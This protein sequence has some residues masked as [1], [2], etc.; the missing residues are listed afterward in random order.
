M[1]TYF[2]QK[3]WLVVLACFFSFPLAFAHTPETGFGTE[4]S[5]E[6]VQNR[7][8]WPAAVK[9]KAELP[10]GQLYLKQTELVFNFQNRSQLAALDPHQVAKNPTAARPTEL[11]AHAYAMQFLGAAKHTILSGARKTPGYRN[12]L[13]GNDPS[14]WASDVAAYEEVAYPELYPGT[15]L[16]LYELNK[17]LK[18][19]FELEPGAN[20]DKIRIQYNGAD[21]V[22]IQDGKLVVNTS[23]NTVT[24]QRPYA[25]QIKNGRPIEV[26]CEFRISNNVVSFV[27]PKGFN[28]K[29][30]LTI[31]PTL[32]FSTY[33]GS[34]ADNWGFTAT[35]DQ[36]GN[37][38]S[39]GV[40]FGSGYPV[41]LGAYQTNFRGFIDI[42]IIKYN[43]ALA[44]T[45]SRVYATYLG[46]SEAD[47][48]H[49]LVVNSQNELLVLGTTSSLNYPVSLTG[50]KR[51]FNGGSSIDPFVNFGTS[52]FEYINGSD[53]VITKLS[54]S[55][56]G[57]AGSTFLGGTATAGLLRL[58]APLTRNSGDLFGGYILPDANDNVYVASSTNS[59]NYPVQNAFQ[60][61]YGGNGSD[62]VVS[63]FN[64]N[65]SS[66]L[67]STYA[68][69]S[70]EDAAFSVQLDNQFNAYICGGT[71]SGSLPLSAG[72]FKPTSIAGQVDGFVSKINSAGQL[73]QSTFI[74]T[75]GVQYDQTYF[76][77]LDAMNNVYVLGQSQGNYPVSSGVFSVNNGRQFIQKLNPDLTTGIFSTRFGTPDGKFNISPTAFL[78]D[79][80]ERIFV[81]G[82]GG[83]INSLEPNY[84]QGN[85]FGMP[86][87]ANAIQQQTDGSDFY[88]M[89]LSQ[90]ATTLEYATFLGGN[91]QSSSEHVDG[92]TSRF[93]KRG[94]VY[95]AVCGGCAGTNAFPTTPNAWSNINR[96][97]NCNNAAFKFDFAVTSAITG[98]RQKACVNSG[99]FQVTGA[100]PPGGFWSG[101]GVSPGGIFTPT[102]ALIGTHILT[103]TVTVGTCVSRS[104]KAVTINQAPQVSFTGLK[105][106]VN[107]TGD[108]ITTLIP[109]I[110]GGTF[111]GPGV[112]NNN[113][114]SAA[115]AGGGVHIITY[116]L[117]D[118]SGCPAS[119][120][121]TVTVDPPIVVNAGP[122]EGV[123][124]ANQG[125]MLTGASPAG[126]TWSGHGVTLAGFFS[127]G[128]APSGKTTLTYTVVKGSC[129]YK[130]TKIIA[131]EPVA[132]IETVLPYPI[133]DPNDTLLAGYTPLKIT[134][135]NK[136]PIAESYFW[137][138]G[139]GSTS[140]ETNPEHVYT[141]AGTYSVRLKADYGR[142]CIRQHYIT[143]LKVVASIV[144]NIIT[145]N[146]DN[147]NDTFVP[148]VSCFPQ[149]LKIFSR[150]GN[151][152]YETENYADNF[153]GGQLSAGLYYY[154]LKDTTGRTWK[155]WLEIVK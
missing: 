32:V 102:P 118:T 3:S 97:S 84:V 99:P 112:L 80:C 148:K 7:N 23:V 76:V 92:G 137:D 70:G 100:S 8:Q 152:V 72:G 50:F 26:P 49:S 43:T 48:P 11:N 115:A 58:N 15:T 57:L 54:A 45:A 139:D 30:P 69:G 81:C 9:F 31:D 136:V 64:P 2:N 116:S 25:Y 108:T 18:Y 77:Q 13:L 128:L 75:S 44:G 155:G 17:K 121:D 46:G 68:G 1:Q 94:F 101:P 52:F 91:S 71:T 38:Y 127:P 135:N 60:P 67:W 90:N 10:G 14:K 19:D 132:E 110:P 147:L 129:S 124:A 150:W 82:W 21:K 5:L 111:S 83:E 133:C 6:F 20:P 145:P 146:G 86:V 142:E 53:L 47:A 65:L 28:K 130:A 33:S 96:S 122:D 104:T 105:N 51:T 106:G 154:L 126:G 149:S 62:A 55:G 41:T 79:N 103:Y 95:Q 143:Q 74:G 140:T 98:G 59:R 109:T 35:Y 37:L 120:S 89:Q 39:G 73:V 22:A 153:D 125:F 88:L 61:G 93:D 151:Q 85:L 36:Q 34:F 141:E 78:V 114:W 16:K 119:F 107:C 144:P 24:E 117:N 66:L 27:F 134:F 29:L 56:G 63:K 131:V 40:V 87:T 123:C 113:Q 4:K 42:A 12:Y 138:F